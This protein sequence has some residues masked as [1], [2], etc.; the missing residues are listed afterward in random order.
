MKNVTSIKH[1]LTQDGNL[2]FLLSVFF[3]SVFNLGLNLIQR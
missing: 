3:R 1:A 2:V